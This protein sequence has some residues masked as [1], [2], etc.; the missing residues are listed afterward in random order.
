MTMSPTSAGANLKRI[1][2]DAINPIPPESTLAS[3]IPFVEDSKKTGDT[4]TFPVQLGLEGGFTF[5]NTHTGVTLNAAVDG[6]WKQAALE[7]SE[8]ANRARISYG[9]AFKMSHNK[10]A[11]SRAYGQAV[12]MTIANLMESGELARDTSLLYGSGTTGLANLGVVNAIAV[13]AS[14]GVV[15]VNFT[16]ASWMAGFWQ[17]VTNLKFEF[18]TSGG[19]SHNPSGGYYTVTAIDPTKCRVTFTA[20]NA[21]TNT[22]A[23]TV[24]AADQV[25]FYGS[26]AV[27]MVGIQAIAENTG[28][29]FGIDA[30]V[31]PQWRAVSYPVGGALNFDKVV[32]GQS[33]A[34]DN[35]LTEGSDLYVCNKTWA[36]LMT[37]E[38]ALRRYEI[39][40]QGSAGK[41]AN[42]GFKKIS[43]DT[44]S[45]PVT[46]ITHQY[47]KQGLAF[48]LPKGK[49]KRVGSTDLT[50]SAPGS[51][52]EFFYSEVPDAMAFELR[53]YYDQ[54]VVIEVP[55]HAVMYTGISNTADQSPS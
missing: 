40:G 53:C 37:D 19:S 52:N 14:S 43:F 46:I 50:F 47:I 34:A 11:S 48:S 36:D 31:Y 13:A 23:A 44:S 25:F 26:R 16:R 8:W 54:A 28:S 4:Y 3:R 9:M 55:Y 38:A 20:S 39:D 22:E 35:G 29:L 51:K 49:V 21:P 17:K 30:A 7:G 33:I 42:V 12:G 1:F 18:Y 15:T 6:I 5:S 10:G 32:E 24:A 27:S 45:G 41:S 2:G